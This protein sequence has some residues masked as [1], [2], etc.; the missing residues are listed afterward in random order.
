MLVRE[1][2]SGRWPASA[3]VFTP[4]LPQQDLAA[5]GQGGAGWQSQPNVNTTSMAE[6]R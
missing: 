2:E 1:G 6:A 4:T 3:R 5:S